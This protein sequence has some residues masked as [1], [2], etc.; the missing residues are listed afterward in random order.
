MTD[1]IKVYILLYIHTDSPKLSEV[2]GIYR[3][4]QESI[5]KLIEKANY[6]EKNGILTQYMEKTN[7]YESIQEL[8]DIVSDKMELTDVDI[9]RI[10]EMFV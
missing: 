4:K 7:D 3:N 5:D 8:R 2:L 10:E 1:K 9:Y 6:R